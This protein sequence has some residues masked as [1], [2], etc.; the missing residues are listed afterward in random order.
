MTQYCSSTRRVNVPLV[1]H[2][3]IC[4]LGFC[5]SDSYVPLLQHRLDLLV[6]IQPYKKQKEETDRDWAFDSNGA[7]YFGLA[8]FVRWY[9]GCW[10]CQYHVIEET[11]SIFLLTRS[12]S[13][14]QSKPKGSC[15]TRCSC[16]KQNLEV[17]GVIQCYCSIKGFRPRRPNY[18]LLLSN[19]TY[20]C[21]M[22]L[23]IMG[24]LILTVCTRLWKKK[25][26]L[27]LMS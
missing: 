19:R 16:S 27:Q 4:S 13:F 5:G 10:V 3:K 7:K 26:I 12:H 6:V 2:K 8:W 20:K 11:Y 9:Q 25:C 15:R 22:W 14:Y 1:G 23:W 17:L 24:T 21:S 18:C